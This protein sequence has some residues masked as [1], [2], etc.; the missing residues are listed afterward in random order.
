M[1]RR[2]ALLSAVVLLLVMNGCVVKM[3]EDYQRNNRP[4]ATTAA[5]DESATADEAALSGEVF[6]II[7]SVDS[8]GKT[9]TIRDMN[10][11]AAVT[12][13]YTGA[14]DVRD[15]YGAIM[16][17]ALMEPGYAVE[18]TY[19]I[20]ENRLTALSVSDRTWENLRVHNWE[21]IQNERRFR[22]GTQYYSLHDFVVVASDGELIDIRELAE[23]DELIVRGYGDTIY[24]ITVL[25]GHGYI[26][27]VNDAYFIGGIVTVGNEV[28]LE[29]TE[30]MLMLVK[31]G[32]HILTVTK[33]GVGGSVEIEVIRNR[34]IMVDIGD[35]QGEAVLHGSIWFSITPKDAKLYINGKS[36]N[37]SELVELPFG[38]YRI[39]VEAEGYVPYIGDLVVG[40]TFMRK[41]ISLGL[42]AAAQTTSEQTSSAGDETSAQTDEKETASGAAENE[43]TADSG[44]ST[45]PTEE[46]SVIYTG[47]KDMSKY[48]IYIE[49]PA[50]AEVYFDSEYM[51]VA[52]VSFE[53]KSG[54]HTITF[55]MNGYVT[56]AY[57]IEISA[58]A[59]DEYFSFLA[60]KAVEQ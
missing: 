12:Y 19:L 33:N 56:K 2:L 46:A 14:T 23:P 18:G 17:M 45:L 21:F 47:D 9:V 42:D 48:K 16:A 32:R 57:T 25:K 41:T 26:S 31:E 50:G 39:A 35:F 38:T 36:K 51:G 24:S 40:D 60:M 22:I 8:D 34:E 11:N 59:Q 52:P 1:K 13:S 20:K 58:F 28:G 10:S 44:Q 55:R 53:K 6:G 3:Y 27:L 15:K 37:Y 30:D 4:K 49:S 5:A 29:I 54:I 7:M 43:T